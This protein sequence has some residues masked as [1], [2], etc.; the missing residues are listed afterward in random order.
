[1]MPELGKYA[2]EVMAAYAATA[3]LLAVL[4]AMTVVKSRRVAD[5]LR[6]VE[7]RR[8]ALKN[9]NENG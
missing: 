4:I 3:V 5:A 6:E 2:S 9:G 7:N 1:M 8:E